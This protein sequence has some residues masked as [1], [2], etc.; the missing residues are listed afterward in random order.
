MCPGTNVL[1]M[2]NANPNMVD[3]ILRGDFINGVWPKFQTQLLLKNH[4]TLDDT[5]A[6]ALQ[7]ETALTANP[8]V[9]HTVATSAVSSSKQADRDELLLKSQD[10]L[11]KGMNSLGIG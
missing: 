6:A 2:T 9:Q 7:I 10:E 4:Q 3:R 1:D 8:L 11:L 5:M